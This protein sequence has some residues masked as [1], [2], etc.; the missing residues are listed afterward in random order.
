MFCFVVL[1]QKTLEAYLPVMGVECVPFY[2]GA[3]LP[4][5][6]PLRRKCVVWSCAGIETKHIVKIVLHL[7]SAQYRQSSFVP[8]EYYNYSEKDVFR[9]A[10]MLNVWRTKAICIIS[11]LILS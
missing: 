2:V 4:E 9:L 1:R 6:A 5:V 3:L 8:D 7:F 10:S 11:L